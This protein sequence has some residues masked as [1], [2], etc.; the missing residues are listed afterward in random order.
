MSQEQAKKYFRSGIVGFVLFIIPFCIITAYINSGNYLVELTKVMTL[1]TIGQLKS[2]YVDHPTPL[3]LEYIDYFC[4]AGYMLMIYSLYRYF[5]LKMNA[6]K[7][8]KKVSFVML[9]ATIFIGICDLVE[10]TITTIGSYIKFQMPDIFLIIHIVST[11]IKGLIWIV[12]IW[13]IVLI[14]ILLINRLMK[15]NMPA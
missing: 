11:Y 1:N 6:W 15:K 3:I 8:V 10:T 4:I 7:G 14:V 9:A 12:F 13:Q 2:F 5:I